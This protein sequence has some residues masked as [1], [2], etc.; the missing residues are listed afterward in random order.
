MC[1]RDRDPGGPAP[2]VDIGARDDQR[3]QRSECAK[4]DQ[5]QPAR[6]IPHIGGT[7]W[8]LV[9]YEGPERR[10]GGQRT[11]ARLG[12]GTAESA[13]DVLQDLGRGRKVEPDMALAGFAKVQPLAEGDLRVL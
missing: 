1:I 3:N 10:C 11:A 12:E 8:T 13:K 4:S 9:G 7:S 2:T 6:P 5:R